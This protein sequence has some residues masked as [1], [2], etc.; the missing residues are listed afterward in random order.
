M[1]QH[2]V[3][4]LL[5]THDFLLSAKSSNQRTFKIHKEINGQINKEINLQIRITNW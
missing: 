4:N 5:M 1:I 3:H 2:V